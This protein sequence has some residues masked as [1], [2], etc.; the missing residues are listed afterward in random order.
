MMLAVGLEERGVT[1]VH[2]RQDV[3]CREPVSVLHSSD[4]EE[5]Q[6]G[7]HEDQGNASK[8]IETQALMLGYLALQLDG[9]VNSLFQLERVNAVQTLTQTGCHGIAVR[10]RVILIHPSVSLTSVVVGQHH[11]TAQGIAVFLPS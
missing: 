3:L 1:V 11:V 7:C 5:R 8:E 9:F 6:Y 2:N 4:I 10:G